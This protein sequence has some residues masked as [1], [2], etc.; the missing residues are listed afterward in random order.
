MMEEAVQAKLVNRFIAK[1]LDFFIMLIF[2]YPLQFVFSPL[3]DLIAFAYISCSDA[4]P[5][6]R[7]LGKRMLHLKVIHSEAKTSCTL[8]QSVI[9]NLPFGLLIFFRLFPAAFG[10]IFTILLALP[11][12]GLEI[13]LLVTLDSQK[14]LGDVIAD[15]CVVEANDHDPEKL[16]K[17][18]PAHEAS[19]N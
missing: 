11:L 2:A 1:I 10:T 5:H 8:K 9:R 13:Y 14:R 18:P 17:E 15:T 7:S 12:I 3:P 6:G 16:A 4:F 19:Q